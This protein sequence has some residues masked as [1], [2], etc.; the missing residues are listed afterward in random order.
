M[1]YILKYLILILRKNNFKSNNAIGNFEKF[2]KKYGKPVKP[3]FVL[4]HHLI[5]HW[6]YLVDSN[7][8][9]EKMMEN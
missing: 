2:L 4:I 9:Y 6:P 1:R 8:N 3:T 5:S 7:C